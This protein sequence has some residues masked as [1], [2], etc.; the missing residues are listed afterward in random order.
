MVEL[1]ETRFIISHF[2]ASGIPFPTGR[3]DFGPFIRLVKED[4]RCIACVAVKG[5]DPLRETCEQTISRIASVYALVS[6]F[7]PET[8]RDGA[9]GI[10]SLE[11]L[12]NAKRPTMKL[13]ATVRYTPKQMR[14]YSA[15]LHRNWQRTAKVWKKLERALEEKV[16]LRL[17]LAYYY[18]SGLPSIPREEAFI[19]AA[20]G[21]E[22]I[23]NDGAQDIKYKLA[24]RGA[25]VLS[26][27]RHPDAKGSFKSLKDLYDK[28][29]NLVHGQP[30]KKMAVSHQDLTLIRRLLHGSLSS[31]LALGLSRTKREIN[32]FIDQ[33]LIDHQARKQLRIEIRK[34]LARLEL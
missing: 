9:T 32:G 6:G 26:C 33:A 19:D 5:D 25:L 10:S 13:T 4:D 7:S 20:I 22:A 23:F 28:R 15:R 3:L 14:K 29:N 8:E 11:D 17:G 21:L 24:A 1:W 2:Y 27:S 12:G 18:Q 16:F 31:Y 30:S 34:G